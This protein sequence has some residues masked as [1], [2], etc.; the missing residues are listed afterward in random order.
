MS[1]FSVRADDAEIIR[2][3]YA[4]KVV[5]AFKVFADGLSVGQNERECRDRFLRALD[6]VRR[7]RDLALEIASGADAAERETARAIEADAADA[8]ERAATQLSA[9]DQAL[10]DKALEGTRGSAA[11]RPINPGAFRPRR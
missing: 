7:A 3:A 4:D 1:E 10:I 2:S 5:E 8:A 9:E 11:L 6:M